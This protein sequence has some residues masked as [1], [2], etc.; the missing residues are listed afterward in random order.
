LI[1]VYS[2][3]FD[4]ETAW[5]AVLWVVLADGFARAGDVGVGCWRGFCVFLGGD[6]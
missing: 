2:A 5:D 3:F 4:G 1:L 6:N